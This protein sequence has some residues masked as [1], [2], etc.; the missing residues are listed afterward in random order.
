MHDLT[1]N[2]AYGIVSWFR[3]GNIIIDMAVAM[4]IP[5]IIRSIFDGHTPSRAI[6]SRS[7]SVAST[8]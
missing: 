6:I 4:L 5:M 1:S 7:S 8:R 3:T 2:A